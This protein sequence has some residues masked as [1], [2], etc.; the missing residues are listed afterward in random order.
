METTICKHVNQ[1]FSY[2]VNPEVDV[3]VCEDCGE[4]THGPE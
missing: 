4:F 3:Y 2:S 1:K